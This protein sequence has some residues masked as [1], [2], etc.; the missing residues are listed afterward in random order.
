MSYVDHISI[1]GVQYDIRDAEAV[2]F[3]QE[4]T[5]T[6]A[7]QEQARANIGA[8]SETDVA[9]LKSALNYRTE[10]DSSTNKP[11][12][13]DYVIGV[14][15]PEGVL[16]RQ[17]QYGISS[18][19]DSKL[20]FA[21]KT[22]ILC[23]TGYAYAIQYYDDNGAFISTDRWHT[24]RVT[25]P[26]NSIFTI[27]I[28]VNPLDETLIA[29]IETYRSKVRVQSEAERVQPEVERVQSEVESVQSEVESLVSFKDITKGE[30]VNTSGQFVENASYERSE[31]IDLTNTSSIKVEDVALHTICFFNANKT[32]LSFVDAATVPRTYAVPANARYAIFNSLLNRLAITYVYF[33]RATVEARLSEAVSEAVYE[34]T[35]QNVVGVTKF[36]GNL[37]EP[38][39]CKDGR[40]I[41]YQNG[42][43]AAGDNYFCTGFIQVTEG[44]T[45]K[46]NVG[47]NCAWYDSAKTY[48]SGQ[49]GTA[50]Q[51][52]VEAPENAAYIR[53]T[54]NKTS[55]NMTD[56][57]L[58]YFADTDDFSLEVVIDGLDSSFHPWCYGK[59]INW[60]GDSIVDGADFDEQVCTALNLTKLTT[61]GVDGGIN[62]STIALK[63]DGTNSRHALCLRYSD[64]PA[65]ADIIA[66]SCGTNDFEYAWCPIG[67]IDSTDNTT[68][69]GA[70]KTLCQGLVDMYP[71]KVIF[72]TTP[73]KRAQAFESGNGGEYTADGVMTTP[74]SKN[75]YG[76]TLMDYADIIKEVCGYY[77]IP[78][79]DM[80]RES[81]L[82]PHLA[83][84]QD[85]F[86]S[87]YTHPN[88]TGQKIMARRVAGW[89]T[90]LGYTISG[91]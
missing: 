62:G 6:D 56:P 1:D 51:N 70:L 46:S 39:E 8:G 38:K 74:F 28:R 88:A 73:I 86:D 43:E 83:S 42:A 64:M 37:V 78:V 4:Q 35:L 89:L 85:M 69:Y 16:R 34:I 17:F 14:Y 45:Y 7:Q 29:D 77:S 31:Y 76:K 19:V 9:D 41:Q 87:V 84:Q 66:V 71:Q 48:I 55:D 25:I 22:I 63:A 68:F 80:Y 10:Y 33:I 61:D 75:K 72:F 15:T 50:I 20:S 44:E 3:E 12:F 24:D 2:S 81:M 67:D 90:Q 11:L 53:F 18:P 21:D 26:A 47:R 49:S 82:N 79:L 54:V 58:L 27:S 23:E 60:I 57:R 40:Y 52:G 91:L 30:L 32:Y 13:T 36:P 5:L 59:T 65:N